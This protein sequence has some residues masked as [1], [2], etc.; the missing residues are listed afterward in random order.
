MAPWKDQLDDQEIADVLT[1]VR[2]N[3]GNSGAA[4]TAEEVAAVRA[5]TASRTSPY[6]E[7]ELP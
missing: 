2:S 4:I 3:F 5:A 1:Y 7:A 6:T